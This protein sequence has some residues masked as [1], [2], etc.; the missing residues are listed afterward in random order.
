VDDSEDF[1]MIL[2]LL[3]NSDDRLEIAGEAE[4]GAEA[5][6]LCDDVDPEVVVLDLDMP[7]MDG[8]T[9]LPILHERCPDARIFVFSAVPDRYDERSL[10][11]AGAESLLTKGVPFAE[12]LDVL[13]GKARNN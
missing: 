12:V 11:A 3:V 2:R 5:I 13:A 9:A 6:S 8:A 4:G 10:L 1:R 7:T